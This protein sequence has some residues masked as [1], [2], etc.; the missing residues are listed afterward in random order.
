MP[1]AHPLLAAAALAAATPA[2]PPE[3]P[4]RPPGFARVTYVTARRAY[5]DAGADD[6]LAPGA[7]LELRRGEG[8]VGRCRVESVAPHHAV[9]TGARARTGD[10]APIRPAAA[11][12]PPRVLSPPPSEEVLA[13]RR[14]AAERLEVPLVTFR[15]PPAAPA[16]LPRAWSGEA[17]LGHATW[18]TT[19]A[20][21]AHLESVDVAIR[22][23]P[24]ARSVTLDVDARAE[25]WLRREAPRFLPGDDTRL[26]VWQAQLTA[27][28]GAFTLGAGRILP[29]TIPGT[30]IFDG[31]LAGL[32]RAVGDL[33]LEAGLFGGLVPQP[34]TT[35]PTTERATGGAFWSFEHVARGLRFRQEG[36][37]AVVRS[38]E[39]G[40]RGEASLTGRVFLRRLDVSAEAHLGAGGEIEADA[41]VDA[42]R[43]DATLRPVDGVAL[44]GG[45]RYADLAFPQPFDPPA[46]PG[47]SREAN[48]F[49]TWDVTRW[50]RIGGTAGRSE[51]PA[52]GLD[53]S[54]YGPEIALPRLARWLGLSFGYLEERGW[55]DGR[56]AYAQA[57][58][59]PWAPLRLLLRGSWARTG[60][61]GL[62]RD[63][64]AVYASA[65]A[66]LTRNAGLRLAFA[67]RGG[68]DAGTGSEG[69]SVPASVT[70]FATVYAGF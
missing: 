62:D 57:V 10:V 64:V 45:Y 41:W 4:L 36:R 20:G 61:L 69:G 35:N 5:L 34:Q 23:A 14:R 63:E 24:V 39:L 40:T 22:G 7:E 42:A 31:A 56:S 55:L 13:E 46:F 15:A 33:R 67:G 43:V 6:G 37:L 51:D 44:G 29:W 17:A 52:S 49:A 30:T 48:A 25:H 18:A 12:A 1:W 2:P 53:R 38:P 65:Q 11:A 59:R 68:F 8:A 60:S 28:P 27:M 32:R 47:R 19:E 66:E 16:A 21:P 70:G 54:W 9:C 26:L 50:L 58:A 3:P